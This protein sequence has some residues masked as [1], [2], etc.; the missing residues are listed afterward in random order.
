MNTSGGQSGQLDLKELDIL[1][2]LVHKHIVKL[3]EI[4]DDP[5]SKK[6]YIVM[7]YL[8]GGTLLEKLM[9]TEAG[10]SDEEARNF[11]SQLISAI[12]YC[13]EV[14]NFAHR[15]IKPEN[16]MLDDDGKLILCDF[17]VSQ[18]FSA[19]NDILKGTFGTVRFMA[20]EL[21]GISSKPIFHGRAIDIWA[22][23]V[24]LYYM[25]TKKYPFDGKTLP[26]I[27]D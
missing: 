3:H 14:K 10:F 7:D 21:Q 1:K 15:D 22:A 23:G 27:R 24:T 6:L 18:F 26:V 5:Q 25:K 19:E 8:S 2:T 4:I 9:K 11:F 16:I 13:H 20:P 17:G 12:H